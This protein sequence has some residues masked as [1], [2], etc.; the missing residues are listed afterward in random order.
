MTKEKWIEHIKLIGDHDRNVCPE[1]KARMKTRKAN[2]QAKA[3]R[4]IYSDCGMKRVRGA[5][6]GIYYE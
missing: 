4:Q 2:A 1:C 6:G 5:M 3:I